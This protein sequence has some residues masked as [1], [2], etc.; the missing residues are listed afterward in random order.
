MAPCSLLD[1]DMVEAPEVGLED[2]LH[3]EEGTVRRLVEDIVRVEGMHQHPDTQLSV[4]TVPEVVGTVLE[5]V[6][7]LFINKLIYSNI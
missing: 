1:Q 4:G 3:E 7:N 2:T 6:D 5:V